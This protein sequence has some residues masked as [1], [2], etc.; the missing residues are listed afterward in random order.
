MKPPRHLILIDVDGV[1]NRYCQGPDY[2]FAH[3]LEDELIMH[4]HELIDLTGPCDIICIS[5]FNEKRITDAIERNGLT[6]LEYRPTWHRSRAVVAQE[7]FAEGPWDSFVV[8]DDESVQDSSA[9]DY[10]AQIPHNFVYI[11]GTKGLTRND[12]AIASLALQEPLS[13]AVMIHNLSDRCRRNL[14]YIERLKAKIKQLEEG[15]CSEA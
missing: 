7:I 4:L 1:F 12:V 13:D 9:V 10:L 14:N 2:A 11:D 3:T 5:T 6:L 15:A 8:L